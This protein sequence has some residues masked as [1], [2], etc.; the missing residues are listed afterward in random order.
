MSHIASRLGGSKGTL[1]NYF[2][3]KEELFQAHVQ[4]ECD[5]HVAKAFAPP[6]I[7][8]DPAEVL[9]GLAERIMTTVLSDEST[10]FYSLIVSEAQRNPSVGQVFYDSGPRKTTRRVADYLEQL[11]SE[12]R[13]AVDDPVAAA[14]EFMSLV[15]GGLHFKRLLNVIPHPPAHE[16]RAQARRA[17]QTFINAYK[18]RTAET[19]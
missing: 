13:L 15:F 16:I 6:L 8:D 1:Y 7:G 11:Q 14:E 4:D 19:R 9:A 18:T 5:C 2:K 17:A 12:G 10:A 3:N